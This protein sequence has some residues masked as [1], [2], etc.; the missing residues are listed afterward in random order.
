MARIISNYPCRFFN[1]AKSI[2]ISDSYLYNNCNLLT[3]SIWSIQIPDKIDIV[4]P[5][6]IWQNS[7]KQVV[8]INIQFLF[9]KWQAL[10]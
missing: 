1:Q 10:P 2:H 4:S 9:Y 3:V 5:H 7:R 8:K 6:V